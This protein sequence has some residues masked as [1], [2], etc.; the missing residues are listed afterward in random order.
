MVIRMASES[1]SLED[2][3]LKRKERINSLK[4]RREG[5]PD[6]KDDNTE[7]PLPKYVDKL[8]PCFS[9]SLKT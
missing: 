9:F 1:T 7:K 4:R 5:V 2:A 3:A 8:L 6:K